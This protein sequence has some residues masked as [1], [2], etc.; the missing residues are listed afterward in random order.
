MSTQPK[1]QVVVM[2]GWEGFADRLQILS[3]CLHYCKIHNASIC[4]DWRDKLWGQGTS[5][6]KDYFEVVDIPVLSLE[7]VLF[8]IQNGAKISPSSWT[9]E[10]IELPP[11]ESDHFPVFK[12]ELTGTKLIEADVVVHNCT[13]LRTFH[14]D[15]LLCN[16][17]LTKSVADIIVDRLKNLTSPYTV[18]HLRGTDRLKTTNDLG[19]QATIDE[20]ALKPQHVKERSYVLSDMES[21]IH[22]W[23]KVY[24]S[25][26][27]Y[28]SYGIHKFPA[29]TQGT[30]FFSA[31]VLDFYNIKKRDINIDT[32]MDFIIICF[33]DW[34]VGNSSESCFT[35]MGKHLN[36]GGPYGISKW[37][38]GF[39][40][41]KAPLKKTL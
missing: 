9:K 8:K 26:R 28:T 24:S 19:L 37:L 20:F 32:I 33:A 7:D 40:P 41:K 18:V 31:E 39:M 1:N 27:L 14:L 25:E 34:I 2:R 35:R 38:H 13:G 36:Q 6:F 11:N 3:H 12:T 5:D 15:N 30:H 23:L 16:I 10:K 4:V 22:E 29:G 17:R 21:M